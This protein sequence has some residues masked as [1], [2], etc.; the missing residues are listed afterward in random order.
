MKTRHLCLGVNHN[1]SLNAYNGIMW[2]FHFLFNVIH[3]APTLCVLELGR[4]HLENWRNSSTKSRPFILI[5]IQRSL[6]NMSELVKHK[7]WDCIQARRAWKW[8]TFNM[9]ELCEVRSENYNTLNWKQAIFGEIIPKRY[10]KII[11]IWHFLRGWP[12]GLL[13]LNTTIKCSI[14]NK[15]IRPRWSTGFGKKSSSTPWRLG[16]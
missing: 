3:S 15:D 10:G 5:E 7:F 1:L 2:R 8:T 14:M 4:G 9:H 12:F 16:R 11:M 6:P 13:G